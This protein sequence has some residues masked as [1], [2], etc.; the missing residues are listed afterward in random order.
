LHEKKGKAAARKGRKAGSAEALSLVTL[1]T[2]IGQ[3]V[4]P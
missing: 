2:I 1:S 4:A 3:G